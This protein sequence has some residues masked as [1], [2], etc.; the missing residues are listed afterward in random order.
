MQSSND[1]VRFYALNTGELVLKD[2]SLP[3]GYSLDIWYPRHN[4]LN[5]KGL[6]FNRYAVWWVF[7]HI[8]LFAN[9]LAGVVMIKKGNRMVHRSLVTP[10]WYRF[11]NMT[12]NEL[13][14]GDVWTTE[15]QRGHGLAKIAINEIHRQWGASCEKMWYLVGDENLGSIKLIEAFGYKLCALGERTKPGNIRALGKFQ[16]TNWLID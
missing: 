16:I 2:Y 13:Q 7:D 11:P 8:G 10:K 1:V 5:L 4:G 9:S 14:I 12:S 15:D 3:S 6:P